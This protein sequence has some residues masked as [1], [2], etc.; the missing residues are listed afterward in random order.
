MDRS[1]LSHLG[2]LKL[3]GSLEELVLMSPGADVALVDLN[4]PGAL[5]V[6]GR[7]RARRVVGFVGHVDRATAEAAQ[8]LGCEVVARSKLFGRRSDAAA[9]LSGKPG[10]AGE[11]PGSGAGS[12]GRPPSAEG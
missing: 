1:K 3:A 10:R 2:E 7:L 9:I 4:R 12:T 6:L 5:E 11:K 8:G